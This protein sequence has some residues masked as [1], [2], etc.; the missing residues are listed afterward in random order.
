MEKQNRK[1]RNYE[2]SHESKNAWGLPLVV[3]EIQA[4]DLSCLATTVNN[5]TPERIE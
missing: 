3:E 5:E 4:T 2:Q 1:N